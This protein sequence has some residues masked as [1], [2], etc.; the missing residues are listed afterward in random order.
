M[1]LAV[2]CCFV[3]VLPIG[4]QTMTVS[5]P[6]QVSAG[7]NFRIA[8]TISTQNVEDFR[9]GI[10]STDVAEII[11]GPYTSS[12]SSIRMVN[13]HTTSSSSVTYTYTLYAQKN[14]TFNIPAAQAVVDGKTIHSNPAKIVVSG[15]A[16]PQNGAP[17]MHQDQEPQM[18]AA[19]SRISGNDL[20]IKVSANKKRVH[21][22]EPVLL[23]YKVYTLVE[24]TQ[25]NGKMPDLTGFH[26]QEIPLPQQKSFHIEKVNGKPYRCVTWSQ[27]VMYPQM[28]GKLEIPSITFKGIVVQQN[29]SV[30]PFEAFFN[31]GSGYVEVKRDIVAPGLTIQVDPLPTR[32]D[33]FSGGVGK[34]N[35]SAQIDKTSVKA[36]EPISIRVVVGGNGN[37]K[38]IKQPTI[39]F[40]KDFD[41]YD[42]KVTDKTRLTAN[43][44]EGNMV[45]DFLAVPRNQGKYTIPAIELVYYDTSANG[46]RTVKTQAFNIDVARGDGKGTT[47]ADYAENKDKDIRGIK[48]GKDE[49]S[50]VSDSFFGSTTYWVSM[51]LPLIAFLVLLI[52]FRK[53]AIDNADL[54]KMRGKKAN[55]VAT[56]RLRKASQ[57]MKQGQA[58]AFYDEVLRA[59]WGYVGDKL[60][61]PVADLSREN[62]ADNLKEKQV[63]EQTI[64]QFLGALDE[65]EFERY[66]P[67]DPAGNMN[68]TF[69]AAMTAIEQIESTMK[70]TKKAGNANKQSG[71]SSAR[72]IL[73]ALMTLGFAMNSFA[74]TKQNADEEYKKGNYQQAIKDYEQLLKTKPSATLYYNLG[75]AYF[76]TDNITQAILA[77][78]RALEL[79]PGDN[80]IRFNLEF[81]R[82]KTIDKIT[83]ESEMFFFSWYR[84]LVNYTSVDR[85]AMIALVSVILML[86]LVLFYLFGNRL[87]FRQIGF[88]GAIFCLL[89]FAFSNLFAYQQ[90]KSHEERRGGVVVVPSVNVKQTPDA[91]GKDGFVIHEGTRVN[92]T[93]KTISKWLG[94]KL[95]DGREGWIPLQ[96]IEEI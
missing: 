25:L 59:L 61:M 18:R 69:S 82:S 34:M 53:R 48:A 23:T 75:N 52:V 40:P 32:P 62:I 54:G 20:F 89:L 88:Y 17:G 50:V 79:N 14:G 94:I 58:S 73:V 30:D 31:G 49:S 29:R 26:T 42:A 84:S 6:S 65:C 27:Y 45:Y 87:I 33:N 11:A 4:A 38:L 64:S 2:I 85:W 3:A 71:Y 7:E 24:L 12:Q 35:I 22:Q 43:G 81:A 63:D 78:E 46:Y 60:N 39:N 74:L 76:R 19:G 96:S 16:K 68:K 21:E 72:M 57:L 8:Y 70:K 66:A 10:H 91:N 86:V 56:K 1:L 41:T 28:T 77:Y 5:A 51:L 37:L 13:G 90:K 80:D 67:G 93:D 9:S 36:G 15:T 95:D 83:P 55:K 44:V 47:I 92:I